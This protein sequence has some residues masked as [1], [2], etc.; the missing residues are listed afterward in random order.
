MRLL[1]AYRHILHR[2]VTC[3]DSKRI[4]LSACN[5]FIINTLYPILTDDSKKQKSF[6]LS[7]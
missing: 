2:F 5:L 1:S 7:L 6:S 3:A 4:Y